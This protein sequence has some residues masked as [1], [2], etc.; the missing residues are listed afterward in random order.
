M[1]QAVVKGARIM[2]STLLHF[3]RDSAQMHGCFYL[4][5]VL[6]DNYHRP[7][8]HPMLLYIMSAVI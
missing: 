6:F 1:K 4:L 2:G 7:M 5:C 3:G 8:A